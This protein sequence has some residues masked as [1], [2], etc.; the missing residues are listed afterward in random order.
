VLV[1][2]NKLAVG[3]HWIKISRNNLA[4]PAGVK[5]DRINPQDIAV[6]LK[7]LSGDLMRD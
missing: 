1:D 5:V 3:E 6:I 4:I 2:L 7:P